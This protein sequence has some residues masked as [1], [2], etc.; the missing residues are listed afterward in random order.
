[1]SYPLTAQQMLGDVSLIAD[2]QE[3]QL[4]DTLRA[5]MAALEHVKDDLDTEG[6]AVISVMGWCKYA[7][8]GYDPALLARSVS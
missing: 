8:M 7:C 2:A 6:A 3:K 1:M 5:K 4:M